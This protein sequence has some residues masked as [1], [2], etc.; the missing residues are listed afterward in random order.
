VTLVLQCA[1][2]G[3]QHPVGTAVCFRV[4]RERRRPV[5]LMFECPT[6]GHFG[7]TRS[8]RSAHRSFRLELDDDLIVAEVGHRRSARARRVRLRSGVRP[9][10][11]GRG[12]HRR[13]DGGAVRRRA[14]FRRRSFDRGRRRRTSERRGDRGWTT[15]SRGAPI[16]VTRTT[17]RSRGAPTAGASRRRGGG[18]KHVATGG[19]RGP[20]PACSGGLRVPAELFLGQSGRRV[21]GRVQG[22][23]AEPEQEEWSGARSRVPTLP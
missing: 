5:R 4:R 10:P 6:C 8:A 12:D 14:G 16:A 15:L 22:R 13:S 17:T 7:L 2:C 11:R 20:C 21:R 19:P 1:M 18:A 9:G 23:R 3:T